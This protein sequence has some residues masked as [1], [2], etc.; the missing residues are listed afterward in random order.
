MEELLS[1]KEQWEWVKDQVRTHGPAVALAVALAIAAI[2]GWRWWQ[3]HRDA[4]RMRA[5]AL[6]VDMVGALEHGDRTRALVRL[7]DLERGY[8]GAPYTDQAK[9][10]AARVYVDDGELDKAAAELGDVAGHS[11]DQELAKV[12]RQRLA[13]VEIAQGRADAALATLGDVAGAGAFS[14][15]FHEIRGDAWYA[16]GDRKAALEEYRAALKAGAV[17]DAA[18]LNLKIAELSAGAPP[19][20]P[21]TAPAGAPA[22]TSPA[23]SPATPAATPAGGAPGR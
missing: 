8:P 11:K 6:Y 5:G 18:L 22:A 4:E 17:A 15:R 9:L 13:R 10:L 14:G 7:G 2:G 3:A 1:D 16:K 19:P 12:A 23:A 20:S 21:A